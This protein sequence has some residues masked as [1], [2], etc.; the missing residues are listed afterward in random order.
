M[1]E[2]CK[3]AFQ[4]WYLKEF[5]FS[6]QECELNFD[7]PQ[8]QWELKVFQAGRASIPAP[9]VTEEIA[10]LKADLDAQCQLLGAGGERELRLMAE[11][12]R[13]KAELD[14]TKEERSMAIKE[15]GEY[16]QKCGRL[17]AEVDRLKAELAHKQPKPP[18]AKEADYEA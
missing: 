17:M 14:K 6:E 15:L 11:N 18:Q 7:C 3:Q 2:D 16:A 1:T 12:E 4:K 13:L 8:V 9:E 10:A 5:N